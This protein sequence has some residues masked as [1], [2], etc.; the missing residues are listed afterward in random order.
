MAEE[1]RLTRFNGYAAVTPAV[2]LVLIIDRSGSMAGNEQAINKYYKDMLKTAKLSGRPVTL[3]TVLFDSSNSI[4]LVCDGQKIG[5][6]KPLDYQVG[7][8]TAL[9]DA[10]GIAVMYENKRKTDPKN[11]YP[12]ADVL[13]LA[14]SDGYENDSAKFD[15]EKLRNLML[16]E[17]QRSYEGNGRRE[18]AQI[19]EFGISQEKMCDDFMLEEDHSQTF[20]RG[21]NGLRVLF[22]TVLIAL[23]NM[24]EDKRITHKFKELSDRL[25]VGSLSLGQLKAITGNYQKLMLDGSE[26]MNTLETLAMKGLT[27]EF[28]KV[29]AECYAKV[30]KINGSL[31]ALE[32]D[33]ELAEIMNLY[34]GKNINM[35]STALNTAVKKSVADISGKLHTDITELR[36]AA[37]NLRSS[38]NEFLQPLQ[39]YHSD[40]KELKVIPHTVADMQGTP[41]KKSS[42]EIKIEVIS[43][44]HEKIYEEI[45]KEAFEGRTACLRNR[46]GM[47]TFNN[48]GGFTAEPIAAMLQNNLPYNKFCEMYRYLVSKVPHPKQAAAAQNETAPRREQDAAGAQNAIT[49]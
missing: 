5:N 8:A 16:A 36:S 39:K 11:P 43:S 24:I 34:V 25:P 41:V 9:Y 21:E 40:L 28:Q 6:A 27:P 37:E 20:Y 1:T 35:V 14:L 45:I 23:R 46:P 12:Q 29:Y 22:Q 18:F 3:T 33:R 38:A 31:T 44:H 4:E 13:Y 19:T 26:M 17:K 2:D 7:G 30:G 10:L 49:V 48:L 42:V 32:Y 47:Q 15:L